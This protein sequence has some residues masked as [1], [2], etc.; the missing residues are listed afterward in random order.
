M[1]LAISLSNAIAISNKRSVAQLKKEVLIR[2]DSSK[3]K[4]GMHFRL[5]PTGTK[6]RSQWYRC[7]AISA[8]GEITGMIL[9]SGNKSYFNKNFPILRLVS[10]DT[11]LFP[12]AH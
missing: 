9:S 6:K 4:I 7:V 2:S 10:E 8:D 5:E 12:A 1:T 11:N 3:L